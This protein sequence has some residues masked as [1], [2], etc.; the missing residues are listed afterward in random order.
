MNDECFLS[1]T[2]SIKIIE[3]DTLLQPMS[4]FDFKAFPQSKAF[5]FWQDVDGVKSKDRENKVL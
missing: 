1:N 4:C 3:L 5:P 2:Q